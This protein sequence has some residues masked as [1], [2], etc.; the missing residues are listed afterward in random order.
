VPLSGIAIGG[1][2]G[3]AMLVRAY[4]HARLRD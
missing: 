4:K 1:A 3:V 2:I